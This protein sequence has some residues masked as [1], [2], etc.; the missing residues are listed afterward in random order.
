MPKTY[1]QFV[2]D[3]A[4]LVLQHATFT[5]LDSKKDLAECFIL[6]LDDISL[7]AGELSNLCD[8]HYD[9]GD[10]KHFMKWFLNS[11]KAS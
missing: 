3:V 1:T 4:T 2:A 11:Y 10:K 7:L 8:E 5:R 9:E 6:S